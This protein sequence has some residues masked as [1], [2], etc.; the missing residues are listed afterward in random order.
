MKKRLIASFMTLCV[1][2]ALVAPV[3]AI[4]AGND[5]ANDEY[6]ITVGGSI[7]YVDES[8]KMIV[9][10]LKTTTQQVTAQELEKGISADNIIPKRA[11]Q[12][13]QTIK[14][15][16]NNKV[17]C[18]LTASFSYEAGNYVT[19]TDKS[20]STTIY[21]NSYVKVRDSAAVTYGATQQWCRVT[22]TSV[23]LKP[24]NST[25]VCNVWIE[26]SRSGYISHN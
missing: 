13:Y 8:G 23:I 6:F 19:N 26:C 1:A 17:K 16:L 15:F 10:D 9:E 5:S 24:N 7:S 14:Y 25:A 4:D 11:S 3:R 21:D 22:Y 18:S 20:Y 12:E 2:M